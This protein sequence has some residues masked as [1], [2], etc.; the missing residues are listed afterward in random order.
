MKTS[1]WAC[2]LASALC[3]FGC[4]GGGGRDGDCSGSA[5]Y[6]AQYAPAAAVSDSGATGNNTNQT[7]LFS[8][9]GTGDAVFDIPAGV[10]RIRIQG[11]YPGTSANFIV[12]IA[13]KNVVNEIV[14][15]T[16]VPTAYDGVLKIAGGGAVVIANSGGVTWTFT[17][18]KVVPVV[19]PSGTYA[20]SG[21]GDFVFDLPARVSKIRIQGS[22]GGNAKNFIVDVSGV[23]VVN[24]IIGLAKLPQA[25]DGTLSVGAGG[26]VE[27]T[28]SSG[29][30]WNVTEVQ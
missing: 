23:N 12:G 11:S 28:R 22:Y 16:R 4:G 2:L 27:I 21:S 7:G 6:C 1:I 20:N 10:T 18:V 30:N 5:E 24:E 29:V 19:A 14:G 25:Y 9:T 15:A 13:K 3:L 17:E 26:V 8:K